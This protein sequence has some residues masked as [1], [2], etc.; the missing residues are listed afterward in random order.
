MTVDLQQIGAC[1][2]MSANIQVD[3]DNK[4]MQRALLLKDQNDIITL[5][6]PWYNTGKTK[7]V[8]RLMFF[9]GVRMHSA[10]TS[11]STGVP[12]LSFTYSIKIQQLNRGRFGHTDYDIGSSGLDAG[13]VLRRIIG[14]N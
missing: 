4:F 5:V 9:T 14:V 1:Q 6:P 12:T 13:A 2:I 3:K 11:F 8:N 7:G 10:I